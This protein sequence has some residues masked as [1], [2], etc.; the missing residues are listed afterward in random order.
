M[1]WRESFAP[2]RN[3]NFAWYF[4]SRFSNTLGT[5]MASIALTFAVLDLTDSPARSARCS[6]RARSRWC[7]S[8]SSAGSSPTG[9][10]AR[11]CIQ[12]SN[13]L[14]ALTQGIVAYL[15]LSGQAELWMLLALEFAN[16]IGLGGQLPGDA[17]PGPLS[18][19]TAGSSSRPTPCS[20]WSAAG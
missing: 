10:P 3:R 11:W 19:C 1:T 5:M 2:L 13:V 16:G 18:W 7:C 17:G 15:V 8:C 6:P 14:S 4:A 9:S 20:P 12:L